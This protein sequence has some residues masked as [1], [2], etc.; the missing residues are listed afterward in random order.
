VCSEE[1]LPSL[2]VGWEG[3]VGADDGGEEREEK[4]KERGGWDREE[5]RGWDGVCW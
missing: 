3:E 1:R 2:P 5:E 4:E